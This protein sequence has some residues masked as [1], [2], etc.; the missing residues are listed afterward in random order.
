M[1]LDQSWADVFSTSGLL[2]SD[3]DGVNYI[4]I[5]V[6]H[7]KAEL[8]QVWNQKV[9]AGDDE[10]MEVISAH[11]DSLVG[12]QTIMEAEVPTPPN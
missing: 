6:G 8:G 7:L 1:A 5:A 2:P 9:A 3:F 4:L 12:I 11:L 10:A